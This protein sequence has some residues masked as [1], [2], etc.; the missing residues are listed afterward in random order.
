MTID[1]LQILAIRLLTSIVLLAVSTAYGQAAKRSQGAVCTGFNGTFYPAS[2]E[3]EPT[4]Y[5]VGDSQR[6]FFDHPGT[7]ALNN[8]DLHKTYVVRVYEDG[9][10]VKS[11]N[12]RFDK[13]RVH[14]VT[15]WRS[16]GYW[17]M[18]RTPSGK[19]RR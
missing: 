19:C 18:E 7:V 3:K 11:W 17:H 15:I 13:L 12:L 14:M 10:L 8:L 2:Q 16:P 4:Y 9:E 1:P 6:F 5:T